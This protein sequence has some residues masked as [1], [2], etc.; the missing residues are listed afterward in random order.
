M[1]TQCR[2]A[3]I[4]LLG[5]AAGAHGGTF[6]E[7]VLPGGAVEVSDQR[8][9]DGRMVIALITDGATR[10]PAEERAPGLNEAVARANEQLDLAEHALALARDARSAPPEP[11]RLGER[12]YTP[13]EAVRIADCKKRVADARRALLEAVSR[14]RGFEIPVIASR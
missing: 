9:E 4:A 8:P 5:A 2:L 1:K 14:Q 11:L 12:R 7:S 10:R 6:Y 13:Q 3:A